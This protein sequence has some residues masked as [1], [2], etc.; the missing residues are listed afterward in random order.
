MA[1][2]NN[3]LAVITGSSS[4]IG[5]ELAKIFA[6]NH[7]DLLLCAEDDGINNVST[8]IGSGNTVQTV[9]ADLSTKDGVE[10]LYKEI[11]AT[12]RPVD[13]LC[14]NAGV[15][16]GKA[17]HEET[18]EQIF[19]TIQLNVVGTTHLAYLILKD[20]VKRNDGHI[21]FTASVVSTIPSPFQAV[22]AATKAYDLS[23]AEAIRDELKDTK[24]TI[25]ALRPGATQ[26]NFFERGGLM[27][28]AVG[29]MK[30]DDP[31]KV[32][33][34]GFDALMANKDSVVG[35]GLKNKIM[36]AMSNV[37]PDPKLAA[38][39]RKVSEPGTAAEVKPNKRVSN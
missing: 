31:A 30:K 16:F 8:Q 24:I 19:A 33:Q 23:L 27:D 3:P 29:V 14:L 36:T 25:T 12:G 32:A 5:L 1:N 39:A 22:Y 34:D 21:L 28:T 17:F 10:K 6:K 2:S 11:Q 15:G 35:G 20:M 37:V 7:Y 38:Q 13:C 26:T 9:Q 4:G 18:L